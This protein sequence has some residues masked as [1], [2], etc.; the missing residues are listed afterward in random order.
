MW[1]K[2]DGKL[3]VLWALRE[4]SK[5]KLLIVKKRKTIP[6]IVAEANAL[7]VTRYEEKYP[8]KEPL[9]YKQIEKL[10]YDFRDAKILTPVGSVSKRGGRNGSAVLY[11]VDI[12]NIDRQFFEEFKNSCVF[13]IIKDIT[14]WRLF[15][16]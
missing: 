14:N 6:R 1:F 7:I 2:P 4:I 16:I 9:S 10:V 5:R 13:D 15:E 8:G 12:K 3:E 11:E